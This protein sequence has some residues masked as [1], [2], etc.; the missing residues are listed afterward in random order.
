M[1]PVTDINTTQRLPELTNPSGAPKIGER[2]LDSLHHATEASRAGVPVGPTVHEHTVSGPDDAGKRPNPKHDETKELD[3]EASAVPPLSAVAIVPLM[4]E[5]AFFV[6]LNQSASGAVGPE[7]SPTSQEVPVASLAYDSR[8]T[9]SSVVPGSGLAFTIASA[10]GE[11]DPG[12]I[13]DAAG[14]TPPNVEK[15]APKEVPPL[16]TQ[17]LDDTAPTT[18]HPGQDENSQPAKAKVPLSHERAGITRRMQGDAL[19]PTSA[20]PNIATPP[21]KLAVCGET[22]LTAIP[23]DSKDQALRQAPDATHLAGQ[24]HQEA[25]GTLTDQAQQLATLSQVLPHNGDSSGCDGKIMPVHESASAGGK[26]SGHKNADGGSAPRTDVRGDNSHD[27]PE[28]DTATA[29]SNPGANSVSTQTRTA[30]AEG[31]PIT[32]QAAPNAG[33]VGVAPN[34][35]H[36]TSASDLKSSGNPP[37]TAAVPG[38]DAD[39]THLPDGA[40]VPVTVNSARLV[41]RIRDSEMNLN[42]RSADLGDVAIHTAMSHEHLS[43]QISLEHADLGKAIAGEVQALQSKLSQ[44]HGIQASIDVQQQGQSFSGNGGQP[45]QQAWRQQPVAMHIDGQEHNQTDAILPVIVS[46]GRLDIRV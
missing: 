17:S 42:M 24:N 28:T 27:R 3:T 38:H 6:P 14:I 43:A 9:G 13:A 16:Q 20:N 39:E 41:E 36:S 5:L 25:A 40:G 26:T 1:I 33:V 4:S 30:R 12:A 34:S 31:F 46:E 37:E 2:F 29:N 23:P 10:D 19:I 7:S 35:S 11:R 18:S 15:V 21:V 32:V 22:D 44:E 45:Q 8:T